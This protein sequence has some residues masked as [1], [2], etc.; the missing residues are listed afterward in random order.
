MYGKNIQLWLPECYCKNYDD[1]EQPL[2]DGILET[3]FLVYIHKLYDNIFES[4][5]T[6]FWAVL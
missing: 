1:E 6:C 3:I 2:H 5:W 4:N